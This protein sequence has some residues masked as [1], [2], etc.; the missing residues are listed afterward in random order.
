MKHEAAASLCIDANNSI[1]LTG[2][3]HSSSSG[4]ADMLTIKIDST[5]S[6]IWEET[7][8]YNQLHDFGVKIALS[9]PRVVV[10]R[11]WTTW[12][13]QLASQNGNLYA[14]GWRFIECIQQ[15]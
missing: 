2:A 6:L 7:Y 4:Y 15:Y 3:T 11:N 10:N 12:C 14:G 8:D 13:Y 5:S 9:G 1:Y